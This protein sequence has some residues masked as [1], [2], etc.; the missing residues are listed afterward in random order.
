MSE[1]RLRIHRVKIGCP[2]RQDRTTIIDRKGWRADN[3]DRLA[4]L[5]AWNQDRWAYC[6][7]LI[8]GPLQ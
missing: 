5:N 3:V 2:S 4:E 1:S 8:D 7:G 6:H